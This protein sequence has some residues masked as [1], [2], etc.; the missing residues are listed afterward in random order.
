MLYV[1]P[2]IILLVIAVVL[3]KREASKEEQKPANKV[4]AKKKGKKTAGKT[5]SRPRSESREVTPT[6]IAEQ[7]K[8]TPVAEDLHKKIVSLIQ[9][10]NYSTAEAQINQALNRDNSQHGLYLHLLDIHILQKDEFAIDQLITHLRALDLQDIVMQAEAKKREY[11][12]QKQ[13]D[14]IEFSSNSFD[15][16][17][18][19]SAQETSTARKVV[20]DADFDALVQPSEQNSETTTLVADSTEIKKDHPAEIEALEFNFAFDQT[21]K[22]VEQTPASPE[23]LSESQSPHTEFSLTLEPREVSNSHIETIQNIE[24]TPPQTSPAETEST[25]VSLDFSNLDFVTQPSLEPANELTES[26]TKDT[27]DGLPE[28]KFD[29]LGLESTPAQLETTV[30]PTLSF[31]QASEPLTEA[32]SQL[33][34]T[35]SSFDLNDP[36]VQSFPE[37]AQ[38]NE[39]QLDLNLANQ[40]IELGAYDSARILLA[41]NEAVF[42]AEQ[43][44]LSKNLLNR[45]AS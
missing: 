6:I 31:D 34:T 21:A 2:F 18:S 23:P 45:I 19:Q 24:I 10:G 9:T 3:K 41:K 33:S 26:Q 15:F 40:Y 38:I 29:Q 32:N 44:E 14:S 16:N 35:S 13:P 7:T 17:A 43:R 1:I 20:S 8:T 37:L 25:E 30:T 36:L 22:V 12:Q 28:F 4:S 27:A 42:N 11:E 39:A 5:A